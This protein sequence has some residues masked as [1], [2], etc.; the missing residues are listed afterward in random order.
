[1]NQALTLHAQRQPL[2]DDVVHIRLQVGGDVVVVNRGADR[3]VIRRQQFGDLLKRHQGRPFAVLS[4]DTDEDKAPL[5]QAIA[6]GEVAWPCWWDGGVGGPITLRCGIDSFPTVFVID[7]KGTVR[8]K[9]IQG[10][11]L[12]EVVETLLNES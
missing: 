7:R 3:D 12:D 6:A 8:F 11:Q 1:M 2:A 10:P 4:V 5:R 9:D